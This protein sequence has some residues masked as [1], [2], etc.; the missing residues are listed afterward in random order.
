MKAEEIRAQERRLAALTYDQSL[1]H[2]FKIEPQ[3]EDCGQWANLVAGPNGEG[4]LTYWMPATACR[5]LQAVDL[6]EREPGV[7]TLALDFGDDLW[8]AYTLR[9]MARSSW[10]RV[11]FPL[12]EIGKTWPEG[13][14]LEPEEAEFT[15]GI[16]TDLF[17]L[18]L[19]GENWTVLVFL[20]TDYA[21]YELEELA[22]KLLADDFQRAAYLQ[23]HSPL[24]GLP[25]PVFKL[26]FPKAAPLER[27]Q[28]LP[29]QPGIEIDPDRD[30]SDRLFKEHWI[31][32]LLNLPER[33]PHH[34]RE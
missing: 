11:L 20:A 33:E 26:E 18:V 3:A 27:I 25:R 12:A 24:T 31:L 6:T 23:E 4:F 17:G 1:C 32:R 10:S 19:P 22:T 30:P 9:A 14:V 7:W 16:L 21:S 5:R 29:P 15:L 28:F 2:A 8:E 34:E 13:V